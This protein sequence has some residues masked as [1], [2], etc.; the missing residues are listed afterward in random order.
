VLSGEA[1]NEIRIAETGLSERAEN[2]VRADFPEE[3]RT[4]FG[5]PTLGLEKGSPSLRFRR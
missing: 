1:G 3:N 5:D 4:R 2:A